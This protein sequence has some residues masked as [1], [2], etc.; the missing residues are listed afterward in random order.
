MS[1]NWLEIALL[2]TNLFPT[3]STVHSKS[4]SHS[5]ARDATVVKYNFVPEAGGATGTSSGVSSGT[6]SP[7]PIRVESS[8]SLASMNQPSTPMTP[9]FPVH[10]TGT[11]IGAPE[12]SS[13]GFPGLRAPRGRLSDLAGE[14]EGD[15][16][17]REEE[18]LVDDGQD[19]EVDVVVDVPVPVWTAPSHTVHPCF[20]NHKIKWSAFI[21]C[22]SSLAT[23]SFEHTTDS[24]LTGTPTATSRSSAAPFPSTS[25][26]PPSLRKLVSLRPA[27]ATSSSAS[28]ES[29]H[30]PTSHKSTCLP[31]RTTSWTASPTPRRRATSHWPPALRRRHGVSEEH[32]R[33]RP[34]SGHPWHRPRIRALLLAHLRRIAPTR[35]G[36]APRSPPRC[37]WP[38]PMARIAASSRDGAREPSRR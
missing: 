6:H 1:S 27:P 10:G 35:L 3:R 21:K 17:E 13:G 31:T 37:R 18:E 25:S 22:V 5:E 20:I 28:L 2:A 30:T 32:Q 7:H 29:S 34:A 16:A 26:P 33:A 4:S 36:M 19:T 11:P 24:S 23:C 38:A 15:E 14:G 9:G 8:A 12:G